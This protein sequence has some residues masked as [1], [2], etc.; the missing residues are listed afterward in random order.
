MH[1][2]AIPSTQ[3]K[4]AKTLWWFVLII[5][6]SYF[7][8]ME[9]VLLAG[10]PRV[11]PIGTIPLDTRLGPLRGERGDFSFIPALSP[12]DWEQRKEYIRQ[13]LHVT[14]GLW[15]IPTRTP[16][17]PVIHGKIDHSDYSVEKVYFESI[18]GFYVTGNLYRPKG[19]TGRR[20]GVLSPHGHFPGGRFLDEGLDTVRRSFM[21]SRCVQLSR[22]GCVVFHYDMIGYGDSVQIPLNVVHQFSQLRVKFKEHPASGFYS[23]SAELNLQNPMGLHTY[24]SIRALDFLADLPDVDTKRIAVTGGSGGGTQTFMLCAVDERPLISVPVVIVS[25][26]RQGGC[27]CENISG[28]RIGTYNLEF[29]A[30]HAPKPLLL[31]SAD[32]DTRT[33]SERG[34]PELLQHYKMLGAMQNVSH[35]ALLQFPHNYN[36]VSRTAM[37]H[38]LNRHLDLGLIEPITESSYERL[39][40]EELSVWD[41]QHPK[42]QCGHDFEIRLLEWLT[43]DAQR[44]IGGLTPKDSKSLQRYRQLIGGAWDVL[45][46][47][48]PENPEIRF[49]PMK[50]T[51]QG[52]YRE[53][54]GL[55]SYRSIEDHNAKLPMVVLKPKETIRQT[56]IWTD[57]QGKSGLYTSDGSVKSHIHSLLNSGIT[58]VGVDLLYQGEFILDKQ[59]KKQQRWLLGEEAFAGWTYCYN[60]PLFA[61]RV[62]DILAMIRLLRNNNPKTT[63]IDIV[64]LNG[65]GPLVAAAAAQTSGAITYA[66]I[67]TAGFRFADLRDVYDVSFVPGAAK[68]DDL[69][70]LLALL[71]PTQ[72]WLAGEGKEAPPIVKSAFVAA[73]KSKNLTTFTGKVQDT[74]KATVEWL[75]HK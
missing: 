46:R 11:L 53:I 8:I 43:S 27:T 26:T 6:A 34:F 23:A 52:K 69:P 55:L 49:E 51:D 75:L 42:P 47:N 24:N 37:Y 13:I 16:L 59:M 12:E 15:P 17:N 2:P 54:L 73:G 70:G 33:M 30:L 35:T 3:R 71:A 61:R 1:I 40:Q 7:A 9:P 41:D 38:W 31:I 14:L 64:G 32:D 4:F 28:L 45:L 29:T 56:V 62:H 72:L 60:L 21:Q 25:T 67:N 74:A 20:P 57:E 10:P 44:Q 36:Y 68:Y 48:L 18:P 22:M 66:A 19:K 58:V 5:A 63:Q 65:T 50:Y 39:T